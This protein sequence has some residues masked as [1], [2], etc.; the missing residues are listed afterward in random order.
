MKHI[1]IK[2]KD[3]LKENK[4]VLVNFDDFPKGVL[5]T[6][7]NEYFHYFRNK[8][9][10]NSKQDEFDTNEE[11]VDWM[12]DN[13]KK[14]FIN[15]LNTL[16][17]KTREDLI[18]IKRQELS[19]KTLDN[20]EELIKPTLGN[21]VLCQPLSVYL[22]KVM[23]NPNLTMNELE[24]EFKKAKN[25][26]DSEGNLDQDKISQ[27]DIFTG[28]EINLPNFERFV[29][30]NPEYRGV[31]NDWKVLFDKDTKLLTKP[32]NAFRDST[33]YNAIRKLYDFLINY[34]KSL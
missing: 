25:I 20:F 21:E 30:K 6:L 8:F 18:H 24:E 7:M 27:S 5:D 1:Q 23:L 26:I 31:F 32:L 12:E 4:E 9:D 11:F 14:E 19:T 15:N 2:L 16:I 17:R 33:P 10:W 3:F 29:E 28:G 13:E 22:Q 34:K